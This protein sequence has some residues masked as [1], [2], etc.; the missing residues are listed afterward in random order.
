MH[1]NIDKYGG[2]S[3]VPIRC[4]TEHATAFFIGENKLMTATHVIKSHIANPKAVAIEVFA[5]D[6]WVE[7]TIAKSFAPV[8]ITVLNCGE[9]TCN[10]FE[11]PLLASEFHEGEDL[12]V[13]GYPQ[14]IG[15]G[16]DYF[17]I[18]IKSS[19]F[20]G[21][22]T[23]RGFDIV[24]LRTD[25]LAF[26]SY[27]GFS[28][29]PVLNADGSVVGVATDQFFNTLSY[30]SIFSI[31][32]HLRAISLPVADNSESTDY[33]TYGLGRSQKLLKDKL[34]KAGER[35][36]PESHVEDEE[37][38]D[39][40]NAF[41]YIGITEKIKKDKILL[42]SIIEMAKDHTPKVYELLTA[43]KYDGI[44]NPISS[45]LESGVPS[46]DL[47]YAL[48]YVLDYVPDKASDELVQNPIRKHVENVRDDL[49]AIIEKIDY[50]GAKFLFVTGDA[51]CGK[52]HTLCR[53][54]ESNQD[55]GNFYLFYGT[56]FSDKD[57]VDTILTQLDWKEYGLEGLDTKIADKRK[58]IIIID[59]INEGTGTEY[60]KSN[61]DVLR[62]EVTKHENIKVI[63]S[64]RKMYDT[65]I[66]KSQIMRDADTDWQHL[67]IQGF[68]NTE[69]AI[70]RYFEVKKISYPI[71]EALKIREF[72]SP[73]FLKIFCEVYRYLNV[74]GVLNRKYIYETYLW[75]RNHEISK[76]VD[77]DPVEN[78][79]LR[80]VSQLV[81]KS[82]NDVCCFDVLRSDA[83]DIAN[84]ICPDRLWD[85]NLLNNL[86]RENI[87]KEYS[88]RWGKYPTQHYIGF[89]YDSIGDYLKMRH[90]LS[91]KD[92]D[93]EYYIA[94]SLQ[95]MG[96]DARNHRSHFSNVVTYLYSEWEPRT[97]YWRDVVL[98]DEF[99]KRLMLES[100]ASRKSEGEYGVAMNEI[101]KELIVQG[102]GYLSPEF[103]LR[104][105]SSIK[106]VAIDLTHKTLF[107]MRL[108]ERDEK[109]TIAT[110]LLYDRHGLLSYLNQYIVTEPDSLKELSILMC[111]FLTSSYPILRA[112]LV[113]LLKIVFDKQPSLIVLVSEKF[114]GVNDLYI[115]QGLYAAAYASLVLQRNSEVAKTVAQHIIDCF[116]TQKDKAPT[117][118]IVRNW[119]LKIVEL[120]SYLNLDY[121]G[122]EKVLK[123]MPFTSVKDPFAEIG[124]EDPSTNKKFFGEEGGA[125]WLHSSLFEMDFNRYIIGTNNNSASPIFYKE[126]KDDVDLLK[127]RDAIAYMIRDEY[128]YSSVLSQYDK[129]VYHGNRFEQN[130]ERIGKKYQWLA[131]YN[132][133]SYLCDTCHLV[134]DKWCDTERIADYNLPWLTGEVKRFDPTIPIEEEL[135]VESS[136]MFN[137]INPDFVSIHDV[138]KWVE[139]ERVLPVL[140]HI[141][142]D[143]EG[144]D[145]LMLDAFDKQEVFSDNK[146]CEC[147]VWYHGYLV[148]NSDK[149][150][151]EDWC[152]KDGNLDH[153]FQEADDYRYH[154]NDYPWSMNYLEREENQNCKE[155]LDAPCDIWKIQTT[156]LQ[157]D[158]TG[159]YKEYEFI[160]SVKLPNIELMEYLE[161]HTA[162]RGI[163]RDQNNEK[164][165]INAF[166]N[167]P[168]MNGLLMRVDSINE[169]LNEKGYTIYYIM[170]V[171]KEVFGV[172]SFYKRSEVQGLC[173]YCPHEGLQ[174]VIPLQKRKSREVPAEDTKD[175]ILE[176]FRK[177]LL[178]ELED[179]DND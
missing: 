103:L 124:K 28:G 166:H 64:F 13:I 70:K 19:R 160:G 84:S 142:K 40:L 117:D 14:E 122:W 145:W 113:M 21:K 66:L 30:A 169:F 58:A 31:K 37:L 59:A 17:G 45:F 133:L 91:L 150:T 154:W 48:Q 171:N 155:D 177:R 15:N 92:I 127:V 115:L 168:R 32:G 94:D 135:S 9:N 164:I 129:G 25:P 174:T 97:D 101:Y 56:D 158:F 95:K 161:L 71:A 68:K 20:L 49:S 6:K 39:S 130:K 34:Q 46:G 121:D 73:L 88:L 36:T 5:G 136:L 111:W 55:K 108:C 63:V 157:E 138:E 139:D 175:Y 163:V 65:D 22:N 149:Q 53:Y 119:T 102:N 10:G 12:L 69:Q 41:C 148:K 128:K 116:Y 179:L 107:D 156:Q 106:S 72:G 33:T 100:L 151:F 38:T 146:R 98:K 16:V 123:L 74:N 76:K 11:L 110:N 141:V 144:A 90:L 178:G 50:W 134:L 152:K 60:W 4:G 85:K 167:T 52:T 51:G 54:A 112:R 2:L 79:T 24:V 132:V 89:E 75:M 118:L 47:T 131:Y 1:L 3:V 147:N 81:E 78:V 61:F 114:N 7:C 80:C 83:K 77:E 172:P 93:I 140:H 159:C 120:A 42:E 44:D 143:K 35:Y 86:L 43:E 67:Q 82:V 137:P 153:Y 8:D 29:S 62:N 26:A 27:A 105:F 99:L 96:K 165:A 170:S 173:S 109:W 162:E 176:E 125:Y 87:L 18:N 57:P 23:F 104:N 126:Q